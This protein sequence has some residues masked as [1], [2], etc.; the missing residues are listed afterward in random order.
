MIPAL[1][2]PDRDRVAPC[3]LNIGADRDEIFL[4]A[5]DLRL[6]GRATDRGLPF[7]GAGG[8]HDVFRGADAGKTQINVRAM[9]LISEFE[10]SPR[11]IYGGAAGYF[12]Y[13]GNMD[14]A[15]VIR[16][17]VLEGNKLTMR[18]GAGIVAD[19]VPENEYQETL[20][21]SRAVFRA[22]ELARNLD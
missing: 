11:G 16:T 14:F 13:S 22:A 20:N 8:E 9:Q 10:H 18:A 12:S 2:A 15:I 4:Q 6:P 17:M 7:G 5:D 3:A 19:S 21:K 1:C